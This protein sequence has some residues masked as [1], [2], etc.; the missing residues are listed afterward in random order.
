MWGLERWPL[1]IQ[2]SLNNTST[3]EHEPHKK[4][5]VALNTTAIDEHA[6]EI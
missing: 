4:M 6:P 5:Q 1:K 2:V 3:D